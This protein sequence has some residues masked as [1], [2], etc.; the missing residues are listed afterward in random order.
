L[1]ARREAAD[2]EPAQALRGDGRDPG[3]AAADEAADQAAPERLVLLG[4]PGLVLH[5]SRHR[6]DAAPAESGT[7]EGRVAVDLR[8]LPGL[9]SQPLRSAA[10][11]RAADSGSGRGAAASGGDASAGGRACGV[12]PSIPTW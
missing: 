11:R 12:I 5:L 4:V 7:D 9:R 3:A 6:R 8:D 2:R 10:D 1:V